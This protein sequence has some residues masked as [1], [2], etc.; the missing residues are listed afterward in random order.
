MWVCALGVWM[1]NLW[2]Q[3]AEADR[4]GPCEVQPS[5]GR[6]GGTQKQLRTRGSATAFAYLK[7]DNKMVNK[8]V[9]M[10]SSPG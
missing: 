6:G 8:M 9:P 3:L 5:V 10:G 2:S 4:E 7:M 1:L